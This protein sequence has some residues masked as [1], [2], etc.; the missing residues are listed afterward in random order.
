MKTKKLWQL[1][2]LLLL[3][4]SCS[5]TYH[6]NVVH[7]P[8]LFSNRVFDEKDLAFG[9]YIGPSGVDGQFAIA[10]NKKFA[11]LANTAILPGSESNNYFG[12]LGLG[13]YHNFGKKQ[14]Y[15]FELYGGG[16]IGASKAAGGG[17]GIT[18]SSPAESRYNRFFFQ[19]TLGFDKVGFETSLTLRTVMINHTSYT[20]S[21]RT[22]EVPPAFFLEP[23][24]TLRFGFGGEGFF[25]NKKI[26]LQFGVA[27]DPNGENLKFDYDLIFGSLGF[28][29]RPRRN[30]DK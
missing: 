8:M 25:E 4:Q 17:S 3:L 7:A 20:I 18:S 28:V 29:W 16:G 22:E 21:G 2:V 9:A 27:V 13:S 24:L 23:A 11:I 5:P 14:Q 6:P 19:P 12:E 30:Y 15:R 26:S 1:A 10:L